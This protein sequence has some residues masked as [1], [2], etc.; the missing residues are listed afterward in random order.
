MKENWIFSLLRW[1][2]NL[3]REPQNVDPEETARQGFKDFIV[4]GKKGDRANLLLWGE[5]AVSGKIIAR[6]TYPAESSVMSGYD[7]VTIELYPKT[8]SPV[9]RLDFYTWEDFSKHNHQVIN[10]DDLKV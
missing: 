10:I 9:Q 6:F 8:D 3:H 7:K 2:K 4:N 1:N 5:N